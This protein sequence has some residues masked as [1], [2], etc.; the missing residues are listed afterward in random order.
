LLPE[1]SLSLY[2]DGDKNQVNY[3]AKADIIF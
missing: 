2:V 3:S 1:S